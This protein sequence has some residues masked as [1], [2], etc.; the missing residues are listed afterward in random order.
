MSVLKMDILYSR[1]R[2][3]SGIHN[4]YWLV[5]GQRERKYFNHK[6]IVPETNYVKIDSSV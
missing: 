6:F 3:V 2:L 1:L 5:I 4:N